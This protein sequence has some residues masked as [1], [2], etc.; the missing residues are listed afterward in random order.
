[1]SFSDIIG[2]AAPIAVL[3]R[4][5]AAGKLAHAYIFE[6][7][8]GCGKRKTALALA[9]AV[10]C[11]SGEGCGN[12]PP[13]RKAA[14]LQHPD[15]HLVEPDGAFIKIDQIRE[16]QK[17]LSYR[18]F[19][20]EKKVCIMEAPDRMNPAAANAFLKTLEEP[21]GDALLVLLTANIGAVLP[22]ILS[23][24]QRLAFSPIPTDAIA[25]YLRKK[26]IPGEMAGMAAALSGGSMKKA[27]QAAEENALRE[28]GS[29]LEK[30]TALSPGDIGPLF[31][32]AEELGNDRD[33]AF[34]VLDLL[35]VFWRD[36]LVMQ[37]GGELQP[38]SDVLQL[39]TKTVADSN[40]DRT[41]DNIE[42]VSRA[43]HALQRNVNPRL[44]LEVLFMGLAGSR[45]S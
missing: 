45:H 8:E 23:R 19:E 6:G 38:N 11:T 22:T 5:L 31:T 9:G 16:L 13:C 20:A 21:P 30:I 25:E 7:M 17:E 32:L 33:R 14:A 43:R 36:V 39:L 27:L 42:L 10:F 24:C 1:M 37:C 3:K 34:E 26:G 29:L 41:I 2:Q 4:S 15:L 18:P 12:C 40:R 28:R 44:A 35:T